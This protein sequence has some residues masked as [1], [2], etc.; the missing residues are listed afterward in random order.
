MKPVFQI[1][2]AGLVFT[3]SAAATGA[4]AGSIVRFSNE[5]Q[6]AGSMESLSSEFLVWTS[7]ALEKPVP[8]VL[9]SVVDLSLPAATPESAADHVAILTLTNGDIVRGQLASVSDETIALDTWYAGRISFNR[10][11]VS[12]MKIEGATNF[13][14]RGPTG[15]DGWTQSTDSTP[16]AWSYARSAF[17]SHEPGGIA[18]DDLLPEECTVTF[19]VAWKS[20]S[21]QLKVILFS[22]QPSSENPDSGYELSFQ[23]SSVYL[24]NCKT[25]SFLGSTHSQALRED[26]KVKIQIRA[27]RKSGKVCLFIN[28]RIIEVW[29][30]PDI[31]KNRF[32][33]CLHFVSAKSLPIRIS[34]IGVTG[35]DGLVDQM[36]ELRVGMNRRFGFQEQRDI[37]EPEETE[38]TK[39]NQMELAN[40]DRLEGEVTS[41]E[42]GMI[43]VKT[44]LGDFKA[45]IR[46]F[47]TVALKKV[48]LERCIR[49]NGD[50]RASLPDG[51][52]FV[53]RLDGVDDDT[54]TG[55]SQNFGTATFKTAAFNRIEF[56]IYDLALDEKRGTDDW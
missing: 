47:R 43:S 16:P 20:D 39:E 36:P 40:G 35:W 52:S 4:G 37:P 48:D 21:I 1:M 33:S 5:D 56:N 8:F 17:L 42:D 51:S 12:D 45:P 26:E 54:L 14:Y 38:T 23:R 30:D 11:M 44:P 25:R 29:T 15:L 3:G 46:R 7:P 22:D 27:S 32:G 19:D 50:I 2:F 10:L 6:L 13:L 28:D 53:F 55:S 18:K 9:G 41:I 49:R 34:G 31:A 24:R